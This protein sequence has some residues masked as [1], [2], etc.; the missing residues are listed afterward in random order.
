MHTWRTGLYGLLCSLLLAL[1]ACGGGGS[2]VNTPQQ[3]S[4]GEL[5]IE[6]ERLA[7][8]QNSRIIPIRVIFGPTGA[9]D[10]IPV[11]IRLGYKLSLNISE[12][13][14][15]MTAAPG[16][17]DFNNE[18]LVFLIPPDG[19]DFILF[20]DAAAD[21]GNDANEDSVVIRAGALRTDAEDPEEAICD[22]QP[23]VQVILDE[24]VV[25]QS[26]PPQ[27]EG[28]TL[29]L[30]TPGQ[31]YTE[32]LEV[33]GGEDVRFELWDTDSNEPADSNTVA[34]GLTLDE[35]TGAITGT[36]AGT[37]PDAIEFVVRVADECTE[38]NNE[39]AAAR[40]GQQIVG[41][42]LRFDLADFTIPV[43]TSNCP[44][45]APS[46]NE[47]PLSV[48]FGSTFEVQLTATGGTGALTWALGQI[49]LPEGYAFSSDGRLTGFADQ[50]FSLQLPVQVTDSCVPARS[51]VE[52]ID[53]TIRCQDAPPVFNFPQP[54]P[55]G[56]YGEF[57]D[58]TFTVDFPGGFGSIEENDGNLPPGVDFEVTPA[59]DNLS[60][61][62]RISGTI[63]EQ[64][65]IRRGAGATQNDRFEWV[66]DAFDACPETPL[67]DRG[68][69][70][71]D[72][73]P[74]G[75]CAPLSLPNTE[76]PDGQLGVPYSAQV[77]Q[78]GGVAPFTWTDE[79]QGE[80]SLPPGLTID[81]NG[82]IT[83]IPT[84]VGFFDPILTVTDSCNAPGPQSADNEFQ[85]SIDDPCADVFISTSGLPGG[86]VGAS[87]SIQLE[88]TG[89]VL[90]L[91]W[92]EVLGKGSS[93]PPGLTLASDGFI[94]GIPTVEGTFN[95]TVQV[96]DSCEAGGGFQTDTA[97]LSITIAPANC[98]PIVTKPPSLP[99]LV[100]NGDPQDFQ[101]IASGGF[102]ILTFATEANPDNLPSGLTLSTG[103]QFAGAANDEPGTYRFDLV[104]TD[105]CS[106]TPQEYRETITMQVIDACE[107]IQILNTDL[108]DPRVNA[109][110]S[111]ALQ[112]NGFPPFTWTLL[113]GNL[114]D[115][116][117]VNPA[118]FLEGTPN[119]AKQGATVY[120]IT[121]GVVDSCPL[122]PQNTSAP[123]QFT[124]Q[125]ESSCDPLDILTTTLPNATNDLPY[126]AQLL[127]SGGSGTI[128]WM[129]NAS[130]SPLPL[131]LT[132]DSSG[133][134]SG[135]PDDKP[136]SYTINVDAMDMCPLGAQVDS[137]L[138]TIE[139]EQITCEPMVIE[140]QSIPDI[141]IGQPYSFQ[142]V[143]L[144]GV[145]PIIWALDITSDPLPDGITLS[146][147]GL[148]SGFVVSGSEPSE[149]NLVV[150]A[151]DSC[152][153]GGQIDTL[154]QL[155]NLR[156]VELGPLSGTPP[157]MYNNEDYS[158]QP[159]LDNPGVPP[160]NW[161]IDS[162]FGTGLPAGIDIDPLTGEITGFPDA[163][164]GIYSFRVLVSDSCDIQQTVSGDYTLEL[165]DCRPLGPITGQP[166]TLVNGEPFSFIPG[167]EN[168]GGPP[169]NW[170]INGKVGVPVGLTFSEID[171]S[172]IGTPADIPGTYT[173]PLRVGDRCDQFADSDLTFRIEANPEC[174]SLGIVNSSFPDCTIFSGYF[175]GLDA[176]GGSGNYF[177]RLAPDSG[178]LP[179]GL[180]V[181]DAD[182]WAIA[183]TPTNEGQIDQ[184]FTFTLQVI[185]F[186]GC[187]F[188]PIE[189]QRTYTITVRQNP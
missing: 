21:L 3:G 44:E 127:A 12:R 123:F 103:G 23:V 14:L 186:E 180:V 172:F 128:T 26:V 51:D 74:S 57:Y 110:Y 68:F 146:P 56:M 5:N 99:G 163:S 182:G 62:V 31:T 105:Q 162:G 22:F 115:G 139:V 58:Y 85:M 116:L 176:I 131:G 117:S 75:G 174:P 48:E 137:Q 120:D 53:F 76:L 113:A 35:F 6:L 129:L 181:E 50:Y 19:R 46:I 20:W 77:N 98:D 114:P 69:L 157:T 39:A 161:D 2:P 55:L 86:Q 138:L 171:G 93:L 102:G 156:C 71:I 184:T 8:T 150:R 188:G 101:V 64:E 27:I 13:V 130:S 33:T 121:L 52:N 92:E 91:S 40:D 24:G 169:L 7:A 11:W 108:P 147:E 47:E 106:P 125:P 104:I 42:G 100:V 187:K 175:E 32:Q 155:V 185:D 17:P 189:A 79:D 37:S 143:A 159:I 59:G 73:L 170:F 168:P 94:S 153:T 124:L 132:L 136:G 118:G 140:D 109:P 84:A 18:A 142:L 43:A 164:T 36:F 112:A 81:N 111:E 167:L 88:A 9:S 10:D 54:V 70:A 82:L 133:L 90:P 158:F 96:T 4:L 122:G 173:I 178:P 30:A 49:E 16:T 145:T 151:T 135:T 154:S 89:G 144:S 179:D 126:S 148:L 78:N 160:Y 60:A 95:F 63:I 45:P 183:G 72:V 166:E 65:T 34:P 97:D 28:E 107:P 141:I 41:G 38:T 80:P 1:S 67:T 152:Q 177:W 87:Y 149:F 119:N 29:S 15:N 61:S 165:I 83:G 25:C 66:V 134:I